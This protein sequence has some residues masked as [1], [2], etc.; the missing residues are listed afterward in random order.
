MF[1]FVQVF[2]WCPGFRVL[3][4]KCFYSGF[5]DLSCCLNQS[6]NV[7]T[8]KREGVVGLQKTQPWIES[9]LE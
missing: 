6:L 4:L 2:L 3:V 5:S 7:G 1:M 9:F 8:S